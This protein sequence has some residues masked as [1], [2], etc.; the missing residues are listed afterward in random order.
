MLDIAQDQ[1]NAPVGNFTGENFG[2]LQDYLKNIL[3]NGLPNRAQ[4]EQQGLG[5]IGKGTNQAV[6]R[7]KENLASSGLLRSGVGQSAIADIYGGQSNAIQGLE[8]G[9]N[10]QEQ[11]YKGNALSQLLGLNQ[12]QGSQNLTVN[13]G[14]IEIIV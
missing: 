3:G 11:A 12:F 13:R 8:S 14:R 5:A 4:Y 2:Y 7:T 6:Q 9:L 10:Q 1:A